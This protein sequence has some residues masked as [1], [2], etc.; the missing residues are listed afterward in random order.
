MFLNILL[1]IKSIVYK[2]HEL[3]IRKKKY[4]SGVAPHDILHPEYVNVHILIII[5]KNVKKYIFLRFFFF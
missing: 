4:I 5:S 2:Y 1:K 3:L